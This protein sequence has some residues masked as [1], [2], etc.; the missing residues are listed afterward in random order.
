[1][2][3]FDEHSSRSEHADEITVSVRN[4]DDSSDGEG[5]TWVT[6]VWQ[7]GHWRSVHEPHGRALD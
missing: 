3:A 2:H 1:M 4:V 6:R 7:N 5:E